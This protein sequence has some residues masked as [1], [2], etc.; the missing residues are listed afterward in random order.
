MTLAP[1]KE[2][3]IVAFS[4]ITWPRTV[5]SPSI[6][7]CGTLGTHRHLP[8]SHQLYAFYTLFTGF[9]VIL[10]QNIFKRDLYDILCG[11]HRT[12]NIFLFLTF[13]CYCTVLQS[14]VV[15]KIGPR[16]WWLGL[17]KR[18][19]Y[20]A[21]TIPCAAQYCMELRQYQAWHVTSLKRTEH[22][23]FQHLDMLSFTRWKAMMKTKIR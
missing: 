18:H 1:P 7:T 10:Y 12:F 8:G 15:H 5:A 16:Q 14:F 3:Y 2:Q 23:I 4:N 6:P 9:F 13:V 22:V 20:V 11:Y 21:T 19:T 17:T